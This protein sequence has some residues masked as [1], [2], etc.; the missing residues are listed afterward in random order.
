MAVKKGFILRRKVDKFLV[1]CAASRYGTGS[2]LGQAT[3]R[4]NDQSSP[5]LTRAD[6]QMTKRGILAGCPSG[7]GVCVRD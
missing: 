1:H 6:P 4:N 2:W 5:G 7:D 3:Q